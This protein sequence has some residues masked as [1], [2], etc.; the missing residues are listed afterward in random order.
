MQT[1]TGGATAPDYR[2]AP[3][4]R[5][6]LRGA[7]FRGGLPFLPPWPRL[8]TPSIGCSLL[9][10]L[11]GPLTEPPTV[12]L[13]R[14]ICPLRSVLGGPKNFGRLLPSLLLFTKKPPRTRSVKSSSSSWNSDNAMLNPSGCRL[15]PW[16]ASKPGPEVEM[17]RACARALIALDPWPNG[18]LPSVAPPA[19]LN[20]WDT[21]KGSPAAASNLFR[22]PARAR[23]TSLLVSANPRS[24]T[25]RRCWPKKPPTTWAACSSS[26]LNRAASSLR[27]RPDTGPKGLATK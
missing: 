6:P 12:S 23:R 18:P 3:L 10:A 26:L 20:T 24:I 22:F 17:A 4:P 27:P 21:L 16:P 9:G 8:G 5:R 2:K 19:G 1:R 11:I 7:R 14:G 15:K 25:S 13:R